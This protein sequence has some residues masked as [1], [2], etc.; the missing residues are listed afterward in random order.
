MYIPQFAGPVEG[1]ATNYAAKNFWRVQASMEWD[2]LKQEAFL[3]FARCEAKYPQLDT[4]AHFMS[5]YKRAWINHLNDLAT[6]DGKLREAQPLVL[7]RDGDEMITDPTGELD[8]DGYTK[9]LIEQAPREVRM[10][11]ELILR[12]PQ[13]LVDLALASWKLD[14]RHKNK[15]CGKINRMLGLPPDTDLVTMTRDYFRP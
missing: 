8:N 9:I 3:I 12:A 15:G 6:A 14:D 5:L 13:E 7:E 2:D 1:W 10:F 4:P 11:L